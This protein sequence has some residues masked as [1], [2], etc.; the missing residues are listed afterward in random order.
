MQSD[1][2][3]LTSLPETGQILFWPPVLP[4]HPGRETAGVAPAE[5]VRAAL[6]WSQP[7]LAGSTRGPTMC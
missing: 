7:V 2:P 1:L 5:E 4:T 6:C 3:T